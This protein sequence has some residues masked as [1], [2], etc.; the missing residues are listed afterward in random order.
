MAEDDDEISKILKECTSSNVDYNSD[1][2][3]L[4]SILN[5]NNDDL[6]ISNLDNE[7]KKK[8]IVYQMLMNQKKKNKIKKLKSQ[9]V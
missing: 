7:E 3:N 9:I 8:K 4:N 1:N 2:Y 6:L 5:E